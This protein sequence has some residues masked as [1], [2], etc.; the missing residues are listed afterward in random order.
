MRIL[1][2]IDDKIKMAIIR[3]DNALKEISFHKDNP[4][5]LV[6]HEQI[7]LMRANDIIVLLNELIEEIC[8]SSH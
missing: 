2:I 5:A 4:E 3:R 6:I 8:K 7:E 1:Q